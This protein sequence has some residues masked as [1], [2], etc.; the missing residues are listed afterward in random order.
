MIKFLIVILPGIICQNV[1]TAP[2]SPILKSLTIFCIVF[3][4]KK[5]LQIN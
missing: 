3:V 2:K 5:I 1:E 4:S